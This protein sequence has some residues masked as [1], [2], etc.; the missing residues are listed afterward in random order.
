MVDSKFENWVEKYRASKFEDIRGNDDLINEVRDFFNSFPSKKK[1]LLIHGP[2]G[3]GKTSIAYAL[4]NEYDLEIYELNA[5]DFRS[6]EQLNLKLKPASEQRSLF[7]KGKLILVD[8]VDGLATADKGGLPELIELIEL[9]KFPIIITANNIWDQKFSKLRE[10]CKTLSI[11]PLNYRDI[12]LIL[13][14]IAKRENLT[15]DN[16]I[17]MSLAIRANGD[18]RAAINDLQT[19]SSEKDYLSNYLLDQRNKELDIFEALKIIFKNNFSEE[20]LRVYDY[21]DMPLEKIML[22]IEENIPYEYSG[23]ELYN[24]FEMLSIADLYAGRIMK[25]RYWRFLVY[26]NIFLSAGISLSKKKSK[27]GH[28]Y[29][30]KPTRILKTW[31]SNN[32]QAQRKS[33]IMKYAATCHCSKKKAQR[34]FYFIKSILKSHF[35]Q[36]ELK[37]SE[38]EIDYLASLT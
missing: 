11:K 34:E 2:S 9:T 16:Q 17:I 7:K 28:T 29:Y 15:I 19:L 3:V 1:A 24:A 21:V 32:A 31:I 38:S 33:I 13:Q 12:Y 35:V 4:K 22:W 36:E 6:K 5:S 10:S 14:E 30:Q 18:V 27:S 25:Q 26:Q 23:E 20:T 37:L 8:E